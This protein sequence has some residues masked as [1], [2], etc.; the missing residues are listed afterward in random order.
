VSVVNV[1]SNDFDQRLRPVTAVRWTGRSTKETGIRAWYRSGFKGFFERDRER[2]TPA[3]ERLSG[4]AL[5]VLDGGHDEM[6]CLP[7][8][9][10]TL[11]DVNVHGSSFDESVERDIRF[12]GVRDGLLPETNGSTA[13]ALV[14]SR[15]QNW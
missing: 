8:K 4:K 5:A 3:L 2:D 15:E 10:L 6:N 7:R 13:R 1:C 9:E 11:G 12:L 14:R